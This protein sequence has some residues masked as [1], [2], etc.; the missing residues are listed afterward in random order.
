MTTLQKNIEFEDITIIKEKTEND[1]EKLDIASRL[2]TKYEFTCLI[3]LRTSDL[4]NNSPSFIELNKN[5]I[6]N[7]MNYRKIAIE[8]LKQR[9]LYYTIVRRLIN[10]NIYIS[11]SDERLDLT[12]VEELME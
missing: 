10:K 8:E 2:L 5:I 9:K 7:N 1:I 3:G 4:S 6:T 11:V 12:A